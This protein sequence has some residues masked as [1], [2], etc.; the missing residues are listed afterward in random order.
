MIADTTNTLIAEQTHVEDAES[1]GDDEEGGDWEEVED[2]DHFG[3]NDINFLSDMLANI[4]DDDEE[5][6]PELKNDPIYQTDMKAYLT[7]FLK[8]C[9][10][11]DINQFQSITNCLNDEEKETLAYILK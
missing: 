5:D 9:H 7:D 4:D 6:N 2:D 10:G 8:N 11:H 3:R 1:I